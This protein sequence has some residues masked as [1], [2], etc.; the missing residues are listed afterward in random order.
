MSFW[1]DLFS[2]KKN[3]ANKPEV[4]KDKDSAPLPKDEVVSAPLPKDEV[5]SSNV[6]YEQYD[7]QPGNSVSLLNND[8]TWN[9]FVHYESDNPGEL[10]ARFK[11]KELENYVLNAAYKKGVI[12]FRTIE[13]SGGYELNININHPIKTYLTWALK[14]E[15]IVIYHAMLL[16]PII[17]V[18]RN[19]CVFEYTLIIR[20]P[21]SGD[22]DTSSFYKEYNE[23]GGR[24]YKLCTAQR[25]REINPNKSPDDIYDNPQNIS[26]T[27][28]FFNEYMYDE[29]FYDGIPYWDWQAEGKS[30]CIKF[31]WNV[32]NFSD[33][34]QGQ[35][36]C[37]II[38]NP[39]QYNRKEYKINS[40][41]SGIIV[42]GKN[43][44]NKEYSYQDE[45]Y[46]IHDLFSIFKDKNT[47]IRW[48]FNIGNEA[49]TNVDKFDG[50]IS[51]SWDR[52]AGRELPF[53]KDDYF[54]EGYRGFEMVSDSGKYIVVSLQ[55]KSNVPY[56]VFSVN[57]RAI[58]LS[59]GDAVD[60]LFEDMFGESTVLTFPITRNCVEDSM[61][62]IYDISYYCEL[63]KSDI[64]C[65]KENKCVNWRI[66][67]SKQPL[68]SVVG[69]NESIWCPREYAGDVFKAYVE[70]YIDL[71]EEL[72][73]EYP[74]EFSS[75]HNNSSI[76]DESCY[77]YL[78]YDISTGYFKIGISN[79]PN[80]REKTLQSEKPTIEKICAKEYPNRTIA[81]AIESALHKSYESK[82]IRGEWFALDANDV[83]VIVATLS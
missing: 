27:R 74:I 60:L 24:I 6:S 31:K 78:M 57:L 47:L 52:V 58:R 20:S 68:M 12:N 75:Q 66:R 73:E 13:N 55:V 50:T 29:K 15:P 42:I 33:V 21:F 70:D 26:H 11:R 45:M 67:F 7:N 5:T 49:T 10:V 14:N 65:M 80:Y 83:N 16:G 56:I 9:R 8:P 46:N 3:S 22:L 1:S 43:G 76:S 79:N 40:P 39:Y 18:G 81:N 62:D 51:L 82:R 64:E 72:K 32:K 59:N 2:K 69:N 63:S 53:D 17:Q 25:I 41:I 71:V 4:R 61:K 48:H 77:V 30:P 19:R 38:K 28:M 35:H 36:V 37:S 34:V 54:E 23:D 44:N